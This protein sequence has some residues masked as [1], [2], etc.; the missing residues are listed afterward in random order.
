[1]EKGLLYYGAAL[2]KNGLM[3]YALLENRKTGQRYPGLCFTWKRF[4]GKGF[5]GKMVSGIRFTDKRFT[6]IIV[7]GF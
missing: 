4:T 2:Q 7:Y 3:D 1:M 5:T 6:V